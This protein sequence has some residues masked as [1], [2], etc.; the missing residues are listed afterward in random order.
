MISGLPI[1]PTG[2]PYSNR[3]ISKIAKRKL[4]IKVSDK[5]VAKW[6]KTEELLRL[7]P[8][9]STD[10]RVRSPEELAFEEELEVECESAF[11]R[12]NL[13]LGKICMLA[14]HL[15]Q[16]R[17][18][19]SKTKIAKKGR[20]WARG[21]TKRRGWSYRRVMGSKLVLD[22]KLLEKADAELTEILNDYADD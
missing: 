11:R 9:G 3:E 4:D 6:R 14:N 10:C 22:D 17:N 13:T 15:S 21:F 2:K 20:R 18:R 5:S 16:R 19:L 7:Q 1:K 8:A 12:A